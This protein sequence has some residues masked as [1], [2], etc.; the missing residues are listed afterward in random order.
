MSDAYPWLFTLGAL[1]SLLWLG[2]VE[3]GSKTI[4]ST[5]TRIDAGLFGL[6]AGL[7]GAR[8]GYVLIHLPYYATHR[9]EV[10]EIWNGGLSWAGGAIGVLLSLGV[11]SAVKKLSYW[12]LLD[13]FALPALL[14]TASVWFGCLLDGCAFGKSASFGFFT[15]LSPDNLG[16]HLHR[17]PVQGSGAIMA[18]I[19]VA[20]VYRLQGVQLES[21]ILGMISLVL[22]SGCSFLL[23]FFRGDQVPILNGLRSDAIASAFL[24]GISLTTLALRFKFSSKEI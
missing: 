4:Y 15:P 13:L 10:L 24:L 20:I 23:A 8:L 22:I 5:S 11:Y 12:A 21:G 14:F 16:D 1:A 9:N 19:S 6:I 17:W 2:F 18:L 7:L 3:P